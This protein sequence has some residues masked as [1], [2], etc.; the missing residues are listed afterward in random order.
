MKKLVLG[1]GYLGG[2]VADAW[3]GRGEQALAV[4]RSAERAR[5]FTSRGIDPIVADIGGTIDL[6]AASEIDTVLFAVGF[7]RTSGKTIRDVYVNGLRNV[8]DALPHSITR[9]IYISST[10]VY[11]QSNGEW[12]DEDSPCEPQREG[13]RACLEAES[14]LRAHP[15]G[16]R[17]VILRLAGIYGPNR[18]PKLRDIVA[19]RPIEAASRDHLNLIHVDDAVRTV[20]AA[21]HHTQTPELFLVSDG[22][23]VPRGDFYRELARLCG[24]PEP[25]FVEPTGSTTASQRGSS[26]KRVANQRLRERLAFDLRYP[27]YREGLAAIVAATR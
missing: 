8:L 16:A 22:Q 9:F 21:E 24:A 17:S 20:L 10:G 25:Q 27:S 2:R 18:L 13:G 15:L 4:T 11:S 7:D 26:D 19:G 23:P 1:C 5:E 6:S 3:I 14:L 12:I